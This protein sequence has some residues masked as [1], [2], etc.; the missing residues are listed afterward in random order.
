MPPLYARLGIL[1]SKD[2]L[3]M[4]PDLN[5]RTLEQKSH[6]ILQILKPSPK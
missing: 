6:W 4:V 2:N 5:S 3:E 1:K